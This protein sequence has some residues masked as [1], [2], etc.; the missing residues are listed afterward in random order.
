MPSDTSAHV[1][2]FRPCG[3]FE[4]P[5]LLPAMNRWAIIGRPC[6]TL[7]RKPGVLGSPVRHLNAWPYSTENS[8]EPWEASTSNFGHASGPYTSLRLSILLVIVIRLNRLD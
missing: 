5:A 3:T 7:T 1:D 2:F 6:G 8:E 4:P